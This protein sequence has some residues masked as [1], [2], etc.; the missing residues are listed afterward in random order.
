VSQSRRIVGVTKNR[1]S[2]SHPETQTETLPVFSIYISS[3]AVG[4]KLIRQLDL[5]SFEQ[6]RWF[7]GLTCDF[8]AENAKNKRQCVP[9]S[10]PRRGLRICVGART[11]DKSYQVVAVTHSAASM[12]QSRIRDAK[13]ETWHPE[14]EKSGSDGAFVTDR[15]AQ[16]QR[17]QGSVSAR[18]TYRQAPWHPYP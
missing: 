12:T 16:A 10:A 18:L 8:W 9:S 3:I 15:L 1:R 4:V 7:G 5:V 13:A 17:A 14:F 11:G 2:A 6:V